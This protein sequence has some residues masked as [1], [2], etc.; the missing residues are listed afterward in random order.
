MLALSKQTKLHDE[1]NQ[2]LNKQLV[3]HIQETH[4]CQKR[5]Q[6]VEAALHDLN[7]RYECIR[8]EHKA[9][10]DTN[11]I[12][13]KRVRDLSNENHMFLTQ[14]MELKE[15]QIEKYNEAHELYKEVESTRMK[16]EFANLPP[17]SIK[18]IHA[19]MSLQAQAGFIQ[20]GEGAEDAGAVQ[21]KVN[22]LRKELLSSIKQQTMD[23]FK[24]SAQKRKTSDSSIMQNQLEKSDSFLTPQQRRE[25]KQGLSDGSC[26]S[27]KYE[28]YSGCG[29]DIK[30]SGV[31]FTHL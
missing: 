23:T 9:L 12:L 25:L 6:D 4:D 29:A 11:I 3:K 14:L 8:S 22:E 19:I 7:D 10:R 30:P 24:E 21:S 1:Q 28:S 26:D 16:L 31:E 17:E 5:L 20:G 15:T 13:D 27:S 18:Q 2:Y